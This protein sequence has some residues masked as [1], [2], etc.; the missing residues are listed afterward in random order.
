MAQ[1]IEGETGFGF[2]GD[3]KDEVTSRGS[4]ESR[5]EFRSGRGTRRK[6]RTYGMTRRSIARTDEEGGFRS[7]AWSLGAQSSAFDAEVQGLV[8][9]IEICALDAREGATF[10]IFT[11]SVAAMKRLESDR[12]GPG[13][14][15]AIRGIRVA[16]LGIYDKGASV[17]VI[18]VPGHQGV[19]GN[20]LAD[21]CAGNEA[22]RAEE[23]RKAR[24]ERGKS[25]MGRNN[26]EIGQKERIRHDE[27]E[28]R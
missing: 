21:L 12:P 23:L 16:R 8:R 14:R 6:G 17:R 25:R 20:E 3:G 4:P 22:D 15:L 11:D 13:Q 1:G 19:P 28:G 7:E 5:P 9:A 27:E 2:G 10:R 18:W 26:Q 24:E